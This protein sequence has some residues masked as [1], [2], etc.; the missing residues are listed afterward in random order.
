MLACVEPGPYPGL[1]AESC[2]G[3]HR[4]CLVERDLVF[5]VGM[6]KG[7]DTA[8]YLAK[9]Y[10]V[11]GFEADPELAAACAARFAGE[12]RLSIVEGAITAS[13][14]PS[15]RFFRHPNSVWGTVDAGRA[16]GNLHGGESQPI[17]VPS[18]DFA[19]VLRETGTPAFVKIDIEGAGLHCLEALGERPER[20]D[21]VSI[22]ASH[23]SW[24]DLQ[25]ELSL[26][27]RLGY[28]RFAVIQQ[29]TIPSTEIE[30]RAL[31]GAPLRYRFE[32]DSSGPFG[33][34]LPEWLSREQAERRYRRINRVQRAVR[35]PEEL[36]RRSQLGKGI[37]GQAI[38]LL[39]PMPGWYDTHA[40]R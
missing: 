24:P 39:G 23:G 7:E 37:R 31:D 20:P 9:G 22:E 8:Y 19:A 10:R 5:D 18:I 11:V 27:D 4:S 32:P 40:A 15:V 25:R 29:A 33:P 12:G 3:G 13:S 28:S 34:D 38:R 26:L 1:V 2:R 16:E 35:R 36:L 6:H 14:E 30:T 17:E 21:F